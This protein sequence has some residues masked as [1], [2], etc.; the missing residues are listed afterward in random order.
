[1]LPHVQ[2]HDRR[3]AVH[4]GRV[5]VGSGR[6]HQLAEP[7]H[8]EPRPAGP[9]AR[10]RRLLEAFLEAVEGTELGVDGLG[11]VAIGAA[12]AA[13]RQQGPEQGVVGVA[14]AVVADRGPDLLRHAGQV[15]QQ[16]LDGR[17]EE[18][19]VLVQ[20]CVQLVH[21]SAVVLVVVDLHGPGVDVGLQGIEAVG[22]CG[23]LVL[24]HRVVSSSCGGPVLLT[25]RRCRWD[26]VSLPHEYSGWRRVRPGG[27]GSHGRI[28]EE[29]LRVHA[30]DTAWML[31]ELR[32][33]SRATG[34]GRPP[35]SSRR[36]ARRAPGPWP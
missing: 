24:G 22:K 3:Q 21:V 8:G 17:V 6:H 18:L 23:K 30:R 19:G 16:V 36:G 32:P 31:A 15:A 20:C 26:Q 9:E 29:R 27:P 4:Q 5:L 1:M 28:G 7:G 25:G 2:A 12:A 33:R 14:A 35:L 13:G 34:P 11:Q 10:R